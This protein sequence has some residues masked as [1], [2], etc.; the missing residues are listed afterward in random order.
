MA[1]PFVFYNPEG[2]VTKSRGHLPHWDQQVATY[3][4]TWRTADSLPKPVWETWRAE[5][6]SWLR[7][8]DIDPTNP[9]WRADMENL[10]AETRQD[11]RRFS[12]LLE[13]EL[14]QGHGE[15][16]LKHPEFSK[17][18]AASLHHFD[19][20]RYQLGDFIVMPNH[21]H[22]VVGGLAR[23]TMLKQVESWKKWTS[24]EINRAL[25]RK[26][27]F[28]QDESFDH[29]VRNGD[30]FQKYR[31]YIRENPVKARLRHG[32]FIHYERP[33]NG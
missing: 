13:T 23:G 31:R 2:L 14:D 26:G 19:G 32:E 17:I 27:R 24:L 12:K 21:V 18:V 25:G 10:S 28:W 33:E 9:H 20:D 8:H 16:P 7:A 6:D 29:L 1:T 30:S 3:F 15:C 22:L 5:R 11:F 4:I